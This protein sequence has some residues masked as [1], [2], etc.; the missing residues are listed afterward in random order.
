MQFS[1]KEYWSGLPFPSP[2][3]LC[4]KWKNV[5]ITINMFVAF[6]K[7]SPKFHVFIFNNILIILFKWALI[8]LCFM[9]THGNYNQRMIRMKT[10]NSNTMSVIAYCYQWHYCQRQWKWKP[11]SRVDS[12]WPHG[13]YSPWNSPGQNTGVGSLPLLQGVFPTQESN[14]GLP[15]CR[16]ILYQLSHKGSPLLSNMV[17]NSWKIPGTF[18][19]VHW[20]RIHIPIQGAWV[21]SLAGKLSSH[22]PQSN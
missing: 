10:G 16:Q 19:V 18:L 1:K 6:I 14:P 13:L 7:V 11:L 5:N 15:H 8:I 20:L 2:G 9:F 21:Q 12:L 17:N 22:M 4:S 3:S